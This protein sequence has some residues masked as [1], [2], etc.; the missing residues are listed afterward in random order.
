M[1]EVDLGIKIP[2][3]FTIEIWEKL[4]VMMGEVDIGTIPDTPPPI[5]HRNMVDCCIYLVFLTTWMIVFMKI[6]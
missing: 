5:T 2:A 1:V 3:N 6:K 4:L